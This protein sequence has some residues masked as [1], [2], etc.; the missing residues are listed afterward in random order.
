MSSPSPL[1]QRELGY[2]VYRMESVG[3]VLKLL[4][5]RA[6][7]RF[8]GRYGG[9]FGASLGAELHQHSTQR[10]DLNI[11]TPQARSHRNNGGEVS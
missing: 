6:H 5:E 8:C 7:M 2:G 9:R 10:R 1:S 3:N 4:H 11:K